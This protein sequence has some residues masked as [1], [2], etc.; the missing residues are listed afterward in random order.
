M[1]WVRRAVTVALMALAIHL[2]LPQIGGL[3]R[4]AKALSEA[5]PAFLGLAIVLE[6]A[7]LGAYV[8]LYRRVLRAAGADVS[9]SAVARVTMASFFVSHLLPGGSA[10]GSVVNVDG[11]RGRGVPATTAG[12][13]LGLTVLISDAT[14][15]GLFV[16]GIVYSLTQG[17]NAGGYIATA[18]IA[19]PF[20]VAILAVTVV[21]AYHPTLAR[22]VGHLAGRIAHRFRRSIDPDQVAAEAHDLSAQACQ[23]LRGRAAVE[24]VALSVA[25]WTCDLLVLYTCFLALGHHQPLGAVIVAYAVANLL[26]AIPLTPAGLGV[27]EASL[28]AVSVP[29]GSSRQVAVLAVLGYRLINYWMPLPFAAGAYVTLR[30]GVS[31]KADVGSEPE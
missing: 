5:R 21:A 15:V 30:R 24:A 4:D 11:L 12:L 28:V 17:A 29:F 2:L 20:V 1:V 8:L 31:S 6:V 27:I 26:A 16:V 14:M 19:V 3:H 10:T 25:N 13:A 22:R 9:T 18:A 23:V 7:S